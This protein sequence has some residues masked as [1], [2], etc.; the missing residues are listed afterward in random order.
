MADNREKN[1]HSLRGFLSASK[2][3]KDLR[4]NIIETKR[5]KCWQRSAKLNVT[6]IKVTFRKQLPDQA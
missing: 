6:Q 5:K 4:S 3:Y 2:K 1:S